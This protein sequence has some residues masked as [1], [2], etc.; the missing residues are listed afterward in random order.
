MKTSVSV[1]Y[2]NP[3]TVAIVLALRVR[4]I[5][6]HIIDSNAATISNLFSI[7]LVYLF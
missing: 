7:K 3:R 4:E 6:L 2:R 1:T 5:M